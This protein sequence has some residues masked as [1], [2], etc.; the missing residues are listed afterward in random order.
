MKLERKSRN[1]HRALIEALCLFSVSLS[2]P[3]LLKAESTS[4]TGFQ[5]ALRAGGGESTGGGGG[6]GGEAELQI[7]D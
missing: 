4:L 5:S 3:P 2:L 1:K 6:A 7:V